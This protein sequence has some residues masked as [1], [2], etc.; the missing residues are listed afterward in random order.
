MTESSV[1]IEE[2]ESVGLPGKLRFTYYQV[3]SYFH[4]Q[5]DIDVIYLRKDDKH[6]IT[7][8]KDSWGNYNKVNATLAILLEEQINLNTN[9][10]V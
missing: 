9:E 1:K 3:N 7:W 6:N 8:Y 10:N 2:L 4:D 5:R